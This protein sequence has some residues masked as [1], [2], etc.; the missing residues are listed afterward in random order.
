MSPE[1]STEKLSPQRLDVPGFDALAARLFPPLPTD[2]EWGLERVRDALAEVG[3]P[4]LSAPSLHVGGT[5]G[6]GSVAAVWASVLRA[7]GRRVGLYTSPHLSSFRERYRVDGR[8]LDAGSLEA[9][10]RELRDVVSRHGLTFFE[11]ATVLAFHVFRLR[12]VDVTVA[13]VGLG[14]RLDATNVLEPEVT[15]VTNVALDHTEFLGAE[16][17]DIAREK[18]GIAKAGVPFVTAEDRPELVAILE[19]AAAD[20][21]APFHRLRHDR[22]FRSVIT[23]LDGTR[24]TVTTDAW[25]E[26][27]LEST[28]VGRHQAMNVALAVRALEHVPPPLRP[29]VEAVLDGVSGTVWPG[30]LQVERRRGRTWILDVAHNPA[31]VEA[32][33]ATLRELE[34]PR[35]W[36]V[37]VGILGDKDWR[38]ML[39]PLFRPADGAF[40]TQAPTAPEHRRWNPEEALA[41]IEGTFPAEVIPDLDEALARAQEASAPAGTVVVTGSHYTVGAALRNLGCA[42]DDPGG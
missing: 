20:A 18:G 29:P 5:N 22:D 26:L 17:T 8:P 13:E 30:R 2:V 33:A 36:S 32:L 42:P 27:S 1:D 28:L 38:A 23:G 19:A 40:L 21:G 37:V 35:P 3:N 6:K 14:G 31:G 34:P 15:A 4:H 12:G 41:A 25:G 7:H 16:L 39:P 10:A 11:A 24:L 9:A